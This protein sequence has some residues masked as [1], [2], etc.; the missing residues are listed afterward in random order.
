MRFRKSFKVIGITFV[1]LAIVL[2][3]NIYLHEQNMWPYSTGISEKAFLNST[4][5][6]SPNEISRSNDA[7]LNNENNPLSDLFAPPVVD[8]ERYTELVQTNIS[9][10]GENAEVTYR[11]FDNKLFEY[12]I[13]L[14]GG[15]LLRDAHPEITKALGE[16]LG[17]AHP[18]PS[19]RDDTV[20]SLS[21]E[22][23][24]QRAEYW[25]LNKKEEGFFVGIKVTYIPAASEIEAIIK[26]EKESYF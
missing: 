11:F 16:R 21:W 20:H 17:V 25:M 9:L 5:Y 1:F 14:E 22:S 8:R 15:T 18:R 23:P 26:Q 24:S 6:M 10:W 7:I 3:S 4:W 13:T 2:A 19:K 12:L